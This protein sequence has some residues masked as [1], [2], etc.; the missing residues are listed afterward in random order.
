MQTFV[1]H[2]VPPFCSLRALAVGASSPVPPRGVDGSACL[3]FCVSLRVPHRHAPGTYPTQRTRNT[4]H[5]TTAS[6]TLESI[7]SH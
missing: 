2:A 5:G 1:V 7:R 6:D 3:L 4:V